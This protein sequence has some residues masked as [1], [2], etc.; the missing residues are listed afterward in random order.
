M[1]VRYSVLIVTRRERTERVLVVEL[2]VLSP[3]RW[4]A[5]C[6][7]VDCTGCFVGYMVCSRRKGLIAFVFKSVKRLG[8]WLLEPHYN[9]FKP[10]C[11]D[12]TS[13]VCCYERAVANC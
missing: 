11:I 6:F 3:T 13:D 4:V 7:G 10:A 2:Q 12:T 5:E 1:E 8:Y 9:G